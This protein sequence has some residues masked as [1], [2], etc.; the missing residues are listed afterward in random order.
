MPVVPGRR[1]P[2]LP[3]LASAIFRT[4]IPTAE[5]DEVLEDLCVEFARR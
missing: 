4:L 1:P 5:R 2:R 3:F